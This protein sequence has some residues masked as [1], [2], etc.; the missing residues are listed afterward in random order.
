[1][2]NNSHIE[3][4]EATWNPITGCTKISPGCKNCYANRMAMRLKAIGQPN[5]R[6]GFELT[7]HEQML[8]MPSKWSKSRTIFVNSMSDLFHQD[9]PPTFIHRVFSAM[10]QANWHQYQILTKRSDRL[11]SLNADIAWV[12]HIWMGV[13]VENKD[14]TFRIDHLRRTGAHLKFL[15]LEPLLGPLP[16]LDLSGID[17]VIV[18]GESGPRAR[19]I[20]ATWVRDIRD[21][22]LNQDVPFFFKQWGGVFKKRNGRVLDG[23]TWDQMPMVS[24][25][26][27]QLRRLPNAPLADCS[28][29]RYLRKA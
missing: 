17:W 2:A 26:L 29:A 22:C 5:Y 10:H 8:S 19:P 16:E 9:V 25:P 4:T 3:W 18:G 1:M 6:N 24:P 7:L 14:Y 11:L 21:Q 27:N 15:S 23:R 20:E 28:G 12:P 13:S